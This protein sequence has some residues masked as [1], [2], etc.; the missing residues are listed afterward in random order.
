MNL[1]P[2]GRTGGFPAARSST[3]DGKRGIGSAGHRS[4]IYNGMR[5]FI[6]I[7]PFRWIPD[8][9][10]MLTQLAG[11]TIWCH[12]FWPVKKPPP[13]EAIR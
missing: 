1:V 9:F 6:P 8:V 7:G 12:A 10:L 13:L 3:L 4:A 11:W 5:H 2:M